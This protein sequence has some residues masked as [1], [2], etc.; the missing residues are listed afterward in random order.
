MK[1]IYGVRGQADTT[2]VEGIVIGRMNKGAHGTLVMFYFFIWLVT[3][4]LAL[5]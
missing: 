3:W 5:Q 2:F 1:I 4:V